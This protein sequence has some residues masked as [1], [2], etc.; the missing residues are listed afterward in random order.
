MDRELIE[1]G[2]VKGTS[3]IIIDKEEGKDQA[4]NSEWGCGCRATVRSTWDHWSSLIWT[5]RYMPE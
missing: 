2:A 3:I 1:V 4:A 5:A